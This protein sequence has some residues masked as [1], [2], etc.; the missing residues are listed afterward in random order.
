MSPSNKVDL[1]YLT[2]NR[3]EFTR[4]TFRAMLHNTAWQ[5]VRRFIWYDA[6]SVDGTAQFFCSVADQIPVDTSFRIGNYSG[7]AEAIKDY[8]ADDPAEIYCRVDNDTVV[9]AHW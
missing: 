3:L 1:I 8:L 9:P 5:F 4:F 7:P 2:C 6:Q